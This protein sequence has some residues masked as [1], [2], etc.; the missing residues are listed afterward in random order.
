MKNTSYT[1]II[2]APSSSKNY[3]HPKFKYFVMAEHTDV[4]L[5]PHQEQGVGLIPTSA[6]DD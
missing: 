3:N 5:L 2:Q 1:L 4:S 6:K